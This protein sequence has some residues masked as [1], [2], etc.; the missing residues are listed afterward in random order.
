[1]SAVSKRDAVVSTF[2]TI[3]SVVLLLMWA[4]AVFALGTVFDLV[5][6]PAAALG[7]TLVFVAYKIFKRIQHTPAKGRATSAAALRGHAG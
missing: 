2:R 7:V 1:M 6:I 4:V 3:F 5:L